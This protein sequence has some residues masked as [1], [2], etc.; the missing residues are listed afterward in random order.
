[1]FRS[2][3]SSPDG[4]T[5]PVWELVISSGFPST[6]VAT[7]GTDDAIASSRAIDV[8]SL[9]LQRANNLKTLK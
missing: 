2:R 1:M 6:S 4:I 3:T 5:H 8:P 9:K 7:D